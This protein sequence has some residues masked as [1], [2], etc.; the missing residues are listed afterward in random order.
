MLEHDNEV[1]FYINENNLV[2][3]KT[4]E[5]LIDLLQFS[6][7]RSIIFTQNRVL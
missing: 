7:E 3:K 2:V 4:G 1:Y 6:L 5:K